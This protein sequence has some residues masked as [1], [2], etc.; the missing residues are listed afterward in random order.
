MPI[1]IRYQKRGKSEAQILVDSK[2]AETLT[3]QKLLELGLQTKNEM[4][5]IISQNSKEAP[6]SKGLRNSIKLHPFAKGGWGIGKI[7]E[8]PKWW[9]IVNYGGNY[10][11]NAKNKVLKGKT[12]EWV[13]RKSVNHVVSATNYI[14][15]SINFLM[16]KLTMFKLGK[17]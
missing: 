9:A 15:R 13:Y 2:L 16:T 17:K 11:I 12:G 1:R 8:L 5:N 14:E 6:S 4:I 7:S 3:K 10:I